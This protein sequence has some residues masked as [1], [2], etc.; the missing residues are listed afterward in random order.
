MD[1]IAMPRVEKFKYLG[2]FLQEK[3]D[4]HK[5]INHRIKVG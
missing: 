3:R 4:I 5:E 1:G 2:L